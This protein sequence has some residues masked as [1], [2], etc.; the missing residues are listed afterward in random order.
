MRSS[1]NCAAKRRRGM[2]REG[3]GESGR[4]KSVPFLRQHF[5]FLGNVFT[6]V[7]SRWRKVNGI[8]SCASL[9]LAD[10]GSVEPMS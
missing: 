10:D 4:G 7:I 5:S 9:S 3:E 1:R 8:P 6:S 2:S